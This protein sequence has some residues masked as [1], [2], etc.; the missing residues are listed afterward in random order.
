V[1]VSRNGVLRQHCSL[2]Q[3]TRKNTDEC[4]YEVHGSLEI[5]LPASYSISSSFSAT[6]LIC[7]KSR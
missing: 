2:S 6:A 7:A 4:A 3:R 5:K 1:R